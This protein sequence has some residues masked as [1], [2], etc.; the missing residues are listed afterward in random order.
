MSRSGDA[1]AAA[2]ALRSA[3]VYDKDLAWDWQRLRRALLDIVPHD[4]A[5]ARVL[6]FGAECGIADQLVAGRV[7]E[8]LHGL[9]EACGMRPDTALW[10]LRAWCIALDLAA[11]RS[12]ITSTTPAPTRVG[13]EPFVGPALPTTGGGGSDGYEQSPDPVEATPVTLIRSVGNDRG[14]FLAAGVNDGFAVAL[15]DTDSGRTSQWR[16]LARPNSPL[17][18]DLILLG[19]SQAVDSADAL[20][21][22]SAGVL[23]RR[24][25]LDGVLSDDR[26][27]L[28]LDDEVLALSIEKPGPRFP[29]AVSRSEDNAISD[30]VWTS[31]RK[32][33]LR[34]TVRREGSAERPVALPELCENHERLN[35]LETVAAGPSSQRLVALTDRGRVLISIWDTSTDLY[36]RWEEVHPPTSSVVAVTIGSPRPGEVMLFIATHRGRVFCVDLSATNGA[37]AGPWRSLGLPEGLTQSGGCSSLA[38]A[39]TSAGSMLFMV[40]DDRLWMSQLDVRSRQPRMGAARELVL[41]LGN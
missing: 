13:P 16:Y 12:T 18:R 32:Q 38:A 25:R 31:N 29:L 6:S 34:S 41:S 26:P 9:E 36:A 27:V 28:R 23:Q 4:D 17:S 21:T 15:L 39:S 7:D 8:A 35:Y 10:V 24:I 33:L 14:I 19:G 40:F 5:A 20:W 1:D 11:P 30:I 3:L 22:D 2:M 37:A